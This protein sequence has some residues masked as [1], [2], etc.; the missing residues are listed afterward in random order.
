VMGEVLGS[1]D[2]R[3]LTAQLF[4]GEAKLTDKIGDHMGEPMPLIGSLESISAAREKLQSNNAL[5]VTFV[6]APIGVLTRH[7]LLTY[8]TS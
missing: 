2:E 7:D 8:L 4:K 1:V 3:T 6:G 5:M